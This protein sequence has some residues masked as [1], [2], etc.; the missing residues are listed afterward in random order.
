MTAAAD[1]HAVGL[2][3]MAQGDAASAEQAL[4]EAVAL[5]PDS[6]EYQKNLGNALRML[7]RPDDAAVA[8]TTA[9]QLDPAYLPAYNN[10]G[11][12]QFEQGAF[13]EAEAN[14]RKALELDPTDSQ[15]MTNLGV[16]I[17][18]Q[19]RTDEAIAL[20]RRALTI[21]ESDPLA[22]GNLGSALKAHPD[23]LEEAATCFERALVLNPDFTQARAALDE[24]RALIAKA[25]RSR[26][27]Q[28]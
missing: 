25:R 19:G 21:E 13:A 2:D 24:C 28:F 4:R 7:G 12:V 8:Y 22:W 16:A 10:L 17:F 11:L 26:Y 1:F 23:G 15:V 20:H 3:H 18:L 6:A 9:L 5:A 27:K 14:L